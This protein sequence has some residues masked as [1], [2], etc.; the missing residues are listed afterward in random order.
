MGPVSRKVVS[1]L[2]SNTKYLVGRNLCLAALAALSIASAALAQANWPQFRGPRAGVAED[3]VL[4]DAWSTTEHVA[5]TVEIPGRGWSS[6]IVWGDRVFVTTAVA[7]GDVEMPKKGLYLGGERGT[8]SD[9]VHLWQVYCIDLQTGKV[10]WDVVSH[11]SLPKYPL[12]LKN[13]HASETPVTDGQRVYA[14]FGNIGLFCYDFAGNLLWSR[15]WDPVKTRANWGTAASPVLYKD[16]LYIINDNEEKSFL[17]A[18]DTKTGEQ[19]WRVDRDE[20]SNWAT[21]CVWVNAQRTELVTSGTDKVRSYDLTGKLLW[22][23]AGTTSIAIPTPFAADGLLYVTGGFVADSARPLYAIRPGAGGDITLKDGQSNSEFIAWWRPKTGPYNPTPLAYR[24]CVYVLY[25]RGLLSCFK[26][27]TGK[28]I[29][30]GVRLAAGANAFTAS[31]WANN[32]KLFCLSED[33]DT[34]VIQAG[35][36]FKVLGCNKLTEMCM[37]TPAAVRGSLLIRTLSK[38]YCIR[39]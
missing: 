7:E 25:D 17:A 22:E 10:L 16:R 4:P 29:Y 20:K 9:K 11:K 38:L 18:L 31:P 39:D 12:H 14:Y 23:L 15:K 30:S 36:E 21:P 34:F 19:V 2:Q 28:E 27:E 26:A 24:G 37:A 5:W 32:G 1:A 35:P 13:S 8:P 3:Q 33:G 6:P